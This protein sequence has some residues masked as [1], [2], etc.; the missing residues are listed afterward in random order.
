M[1]YTEISRRA[2]RLALAGA[3]VA[4][5][6]PLAAAQDTRTS[7][8]E[9]QKAQKAADV[10]PYQPGKAE[11]IF[12]WA[13]DSFLRPKPGFVPL[14]TSIPK[15]DDVIHSGGIAWGGAY[16]GYFRDH[17]GWMATGLITISGYKHVQLSADAPR[18]VAKRVDLRAVTGWTEGTGVPFYGVGS[19]T[20]KD[21]GTS[22]GVKFGYVGGQARVRP[23]RWLPIEGT[24]AWEDYSTAEGSGSKPSIETVFTPATAPGL[25]SNPTYLHAS[26]SAGVDWRPGP[27]YARR[28][29]YYGVR[30]NYYG[31]VD[32][33][34]TFD[35]L[36]AQVVQHIPILRENWVLSL[37]GQVQTVLSDSDAVPYFL[38][39]L[40][41]SGHTLRGFDTARF[42]DRHSMLMQGEWR[43]IPNRRF[44][45]LA[46]FYDL[47]K[48]VSERSQLGFNGLSSDFGVGVR[49][50]GPLATPVRIDIAHGR[51]GTRLV[52]AGSAVF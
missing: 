12:N 10:T 20:S 8:I 24:F 28:G 21:D 31:D 32:D 1:A 35:R 47:G 19:G 39:P 7:V 43:W 16:R 45:D 6:A 44:L 26:A 5:V 52:W 36:D 51:E 49:F 42:R 2:L 37:R 22:F 14:I 17:A 27:G 23:A 13:V 15:G 11:Q 40:L 41:G 9:E 30:Y 25:G 4:L 18:L 33:T 48:V 3:V 34:Y 46:L 29:G 50:H 38:L